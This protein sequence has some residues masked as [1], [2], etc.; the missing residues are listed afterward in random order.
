MSS[1]VEGVGR[2]KMAYFMAQRKLLLGKMKERKIPAHLYT[3]RILGDANKPMKAISH[4]LKFIGGIYFDNSRERAVPCSPQLIVK[5]LKATID[6]CIGPLY[7]LSSDEAQY[8]THGTNTNTGAVGVQMMMTRHAGFVSKMMEGILEPSGLEAMEDQRMV[9][10]QLSTL[11]LLLVLGFAPGEDTEASLLSPLVCPFPLPMNIEACA[12]SNALADQLNSLGEDGPHAE[13]RSCLAREVNKLCFDDGVHSSVR[14]GA[15][16]FVAAV[17]D[18]AV[19]AGLPLPRISVGVT[20]P[21]PEHKMPPTGMSPMAFAQWNE[22]LN[23]LTSIPQASGGGGN[24]LM[25]LLRRDP[26]H[27]RSML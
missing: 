10:N 18:A 23:E 26:T 1:G 19:N 12:A 27:A 14:A 2:D 7:R 9:G 5:L 21:A 6:V 8:L 11:E 3:T 24:P 16:A 15:R 17:L 13:A 22:F 4:G 25:A 20:Q